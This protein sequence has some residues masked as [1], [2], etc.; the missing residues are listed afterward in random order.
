MWE[1]PAKPVPLNAGDPDDDESPVEAFPWHDASLSE[2]WWN[3]AYGFEEVEWT[4]F[5]FD[6]PVDPEPA[7]KSRPRGPAQIIPMRN[8]KRS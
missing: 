5:D 2:R 1:S 3:V 6:A 8:K 4:P 7:P